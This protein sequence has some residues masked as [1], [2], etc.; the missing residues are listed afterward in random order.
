MSH[1][2]NKGLGRLWSQ[3]PVSEFWGLSAQIMSTQSNNQGDTHTRAH[4]RKCM[5][6]CGHCVP[7]DTHHVQTQ[8][9]CPET[10]LVL[11]TTSRA[12]VLGGLWL[13]KSQG[14]P[15]H[16]LTATLLQV[17]WRVRVL[18]SS[19]PSLPTALVCRLRASPRE[20]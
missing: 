10:G 11:Q 5:H 3:S 16:A 20:G 4:T 18:P 12:S 6:T 19:C 7:E 13:R 9:V 14:A 15:A 17:P 1:Y 2:R 8:T